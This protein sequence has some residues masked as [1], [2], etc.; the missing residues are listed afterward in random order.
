MGA[1]GAS[2]SGTSDECKSEEEKKKSESDGFVVVDEKAKKDEITEDELFQIR[3]D[4]T[5]RQME[6]MGFDNDGDWLKQLLIAKDLDIS[7]FLDAMKSSR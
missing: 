6:G 2:G 4:E 5:L 3:L 1:Q 7:R